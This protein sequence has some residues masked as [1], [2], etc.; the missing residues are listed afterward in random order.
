MK[1]GFNMANKKERLKTIQA[2][3]L[4]TEYCIIE[5]K[6]KFLGLTVSNYLRMVALHANVDINIQT[7][8]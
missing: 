3:V 5:K 6:A 1:G 2:R 8:K 4:D 7:K